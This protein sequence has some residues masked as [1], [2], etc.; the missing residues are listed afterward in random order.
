MLG[1]TLPYFGMTM[2]VQA[3]IYKPGYDDFILLVDYFKTA[4]PEIADWMEENMVHD[5]LSY[6]EDWNEVIIEDVLATGTPCASA[7]LSMIAC[8]VSSLWDDNFDYNSFLFTGLNS[9]VGAI[10]AKGSIAL[11]SMGHGK[12]ILSGVAANFEIFDLSGAC[13]YSAKN[14][15][16]V[17]ET[18]LNSGA[19]VVKAT[20][21]NGNA[22]TLKVVF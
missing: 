5:I 11:K 10:S 2:P 9:G 22:S 19:Y 13:V 1:G 16:G 20:D 14:Q 4:N 8:S 17:V 15:S 3:Y 12:V 21:A 6:D 7:D 18:G